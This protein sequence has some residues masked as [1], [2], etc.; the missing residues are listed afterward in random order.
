LCRATYAKRAGRFLGWLDAGGAASVEGDPLADPDAFTAVARDRR[1]C[2]LTVAKAAPAT[3][4][5]SL[6]ALVALG[7][8]LGR[9]APD[10]A[11][12]DQ[13]ARAPRALGEDEA[14]RL[15]RAARRTGSTR[16]RALLAL[17]CPGPGCGWP[18]PPRS[19]ST[20]YHH[21]AHRRGAR[22]R[23]QGGSDRAPSRCRPTPA[24]GCG[25]GSPSVCPAPAR[26]AGRTPALWLGR[27]GR[28]SARQL[29]RIV[30]ELGADA[31]L[32]DVSAHTLRHAA[33]TRWLRA[34]V[35][36]VV[37]AGLLGHASLDTTRTYALPTDE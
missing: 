10:V 35:D 21:R 28:L 25:A 22:A 12:V 15:L 37:V 24:A 7:E 6:A 29:Q 9:G 5:V 13:P 3:V 36:V 14:R 8:C 34:G 23:R 30:A 1:A 18:R 2:L 16:G 27:R 33:A 17:C 11:R 32:V 31:R 19:T 20:T 4:N 26:P